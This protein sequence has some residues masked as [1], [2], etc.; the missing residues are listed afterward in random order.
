VN[1]LYVLFFFELPKYLKRAEK[2]YFSCIQVGIKKTTTTTTN[3][4][5]KTTAWEGKNK[6]KNERKMKKK[7]YS[8]S[9]RGFLGRG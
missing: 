6:N 8:L 4:S 7:M 3:R 2:K 5:T 9:T 1:S